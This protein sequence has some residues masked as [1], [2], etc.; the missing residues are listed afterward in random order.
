MIFKKTFPLVVLRKRKYPIWVLGLKRIQR[1]FCGIR[2]RGNEWLLFPIYRLLS[3]VS[4]KIS[5]FSK[6]CLETLVLVLIQRANQ[7]P[8]W[9]LY[10]CPWLP[11]I[12]KLIICFPSAKF[13][14]GYFVLP[15][16]NHML[17]QY[18]TD[19]CYVFK[20]IHYLKTAIHR[21]KSKRF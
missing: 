4:A 9:V 20:N 19:S 12:K 15:N 8:N 18:P 13:E 10:N 5:S 21:C 2:K 1:N 14:I 7:A 16:V 11:N 6:S 3:T 17:Y